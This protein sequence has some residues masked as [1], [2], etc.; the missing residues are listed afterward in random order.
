VLFIGNR[1][2]SV[3]AAGRDQR[4]DLGVG[5]FPVQGVDMEEGDIPF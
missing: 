4:G 5:D 1:D 3:S 2:G